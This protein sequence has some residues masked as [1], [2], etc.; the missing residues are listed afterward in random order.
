MMAPPKML[1]A[2]AVR[3]RRRLR[4]MGFIVRKDHSSL[5]ERQ[6]GFLSAM[7]DVHYIAILDNVV[8]AF[9]T[10]RATGAGIG[11]G[12]GI[13]ELVPADGFG[14]DKVFLEIG[15]DGTGSFDRASMNR[16]GPGA[17]FVFA[18]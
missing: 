7:A 16:D 14:A 5:L 10:K 9:E 11:F 2:A 3:P 8:F 1:A 4:T 17:A 6:D 18:G 15:V 13:E 12:S